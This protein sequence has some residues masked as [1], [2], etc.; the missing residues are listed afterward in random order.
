MVLEHA[1]PFTFHGIQRAGDGMLSFWAQS[2]AS[3]VRRIGCRF[4]SVLNDL[5]VSM[6]FFWRRREAE[7]A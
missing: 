2:A 5:L 6:S 1:A 4:L 7:Y 3:I